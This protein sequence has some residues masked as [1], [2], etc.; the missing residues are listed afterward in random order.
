MTNIKREWRAKLAVS[1]PTVNTKRHR[2]AQ[3]AQQGRV[4][5]QLKLEISQQYQGCAW[6]GKI[7]PN[8]TQSHRL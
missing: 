4:T 3:V 6:C 7:P 2:A 8:F 5:A 1:R